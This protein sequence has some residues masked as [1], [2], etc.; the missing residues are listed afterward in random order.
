VREGMICLW[1]CALGYV[2]LHIGTNGDRVYRE[3]GERR[4]RDREES[5]I[6]R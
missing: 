5:E 4:E 6:G 3:E 2:G 1:M